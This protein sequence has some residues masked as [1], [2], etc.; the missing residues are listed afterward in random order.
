MV[1][2]SSKKYACETCIKGHRSSTCKHTDRPL[3]EIKKKGRPV[4]QCE[5]CRSLRKTK[6][7][8]VKCICE[9]KAEAPPPTQPS[10]SG[11]KGTK[12]PQSAAFPNGL[13]HELEA[14]VAFQL[15]EEFLS[16][17]LHGV[18]EQN[19]CSCKS[20]GPCQCCTPRNSAA[21]RNTV[22]DINAGTQQV[23]Y[24]SPIPIGQP[25]VRL[26]MSHILARVKELRPVL[27][28][29]ASSNSSGSGPIHDL[30]SGVPHSHP[31]RYHVHDNVMFSPY[32]RAHE[33]AHD[34]PLGYEKHP[35][36]P[37]YQPFVKGEN[38]YDQPM[39]DS[40]SFPLGSLPLMPSCGC[41]GATSREANN[42]TIIPNVDTDSTSN[43]C[44]DSSFLLPPSQQSNQRM[45]IDEWLRQVPLPTSAPNKTTFQSGI[46]Q[47]EARR[48]GGN[49]FTDST[50]STWDQAA[51]LPPFN[52]RAQPCDDTRTHASTPEYSGSQCSCPPRSCQCPDRGYFFNSDV[53]NPISSVNGK[54]LG[55]DERFSQL[56]MSHGMSRS[57]THLVLPDLYQTRPYSTPLQKGLGALRPN[58]DFPY[59]ASTSALDGEAD[60]V[61]NSQSVVQA[62]LDLPI[63]PN[64]SMTTPSLDV[65]W[66]MSTDDGAGVLPVYPYA[67]SSSGTD[68][69]S[70]YDDLSMTLRTPL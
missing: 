5:H 58:V 18:K 65:S 32:G 8:H 52:H 63:L 12:I 39:L 35:P 24:E 10:S 57:D 47:P 1:L 17:S 33:R 36:I 48:F 28:R 16:D 13:P 38:I 19:S 50:I 7:V 20:G 29:P 56:Q 46:V 3:Y 25:P 14:A 23:N 59:S 51:L 53:Y 62:L 22:G 27:P 2:I 69:T 68:G 64:M 60:Y 61:S 34:H 44:L 70:S 67:M 9:V 15:Q 11:K 31:T 4:T 40:D 49:N 6:Q 45:A 41:G 54:A 37:P 42:A 55:E 43:A 21:R 66:L 26:S 30:S